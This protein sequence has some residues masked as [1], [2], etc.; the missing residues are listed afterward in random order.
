[1]IAIMP[2]AN[3][4]FKGLYRSADKIEER[5]GVFVVVCK[6]EDSYYLLDVDHSEDVNGAI[7]SHGRRGCWERH[8]RGPIIYSIMYT[9][10]MSAKE[11]AEIEEKIRGRYR[12]IPCHPD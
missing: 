12:S 5:A 1:M 3:Y 10:K 11:R 6:F 4:P 8:R 2:I 7:R 9:D